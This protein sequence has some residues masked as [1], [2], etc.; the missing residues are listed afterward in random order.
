MTEEDFVKIDHVKLI[1]RK[2]SFGK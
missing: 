1:K 2:K